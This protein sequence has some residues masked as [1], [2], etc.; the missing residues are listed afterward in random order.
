MGRVVG[1]RAGGSD[2]DRSRAGPGR[3]R[4]R[5][6]PVRQCGAAARWA[7]AAAANRPGRTARVRLPG[8]LGAGDAQ[9]LHTADLAVVAGYRGGD[10]AEHGHR[11]GSATP[12]RLVHSSVGR[13][14]KAGR[15]G[16]SPPLPGRLR[17]PIPRP[18]GGVPD[19]RTSAGARA[20]RRRR[21]NQRPASRDQA[22]D[23]SPARRRRRPAKPPAYGGQPR[24]GVVR[25]HA[26]GR[27]HRRPPAV[28]E[29]RA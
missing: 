11:P 7:D 20:S 17:W 9:R 8:E 1:V 16:R 25:C 23:P 13:A 3:R 18:P 14:A 19:L 10:Q 15:A 27:A 12:R 21:H 24:R 4:Y 2:L 22:P 29:V 5:L 28:R 6:C 26:P